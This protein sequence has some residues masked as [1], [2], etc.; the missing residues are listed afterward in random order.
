[1]TTE[2]PDTNAPPMPVQLGSWGNVFLSF[3]G[4]LPEPIIGAALPYAHRQGESVSH[5][6]IRQR[7]SNPFDRPSRDPRLIDI[8]TSQSVH[9]NEISRGVVIQR[10]RPQIER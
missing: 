3:P 5:V 2:H 9:R 1:M 10:D 4:L 6:A 7:G 8:Q